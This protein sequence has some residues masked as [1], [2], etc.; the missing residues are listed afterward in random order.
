MPLEQLQQWR[1]SGF[2]GL[3]QFRRVICVML[4]EQL[5]AKVTHTVHKGN[6]RYELWKRLYHSG[7][8]LLHTTEV[9]SPGT[10]LVLSFI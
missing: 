10:L 2:P 8:K 7:V 1:A 6:T 9:Q 5:P 4:P 3:G